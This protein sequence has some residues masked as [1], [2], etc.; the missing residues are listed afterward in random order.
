MSLSPFIQALLNLTRKR[1]VFI[2]YY[3]DGDQLYYD[4]FSRV[5]SQTYGIVRDNSVMRLILS[6]DAEY[7][8]RRIRE[9]H[10]TGSSCTI[11]LCGPGTPER[12]FVDWEIKATLDKEH[13]LIGVRLPHLPIVP[14]PPNGACYK[15]A[16]LQD[17][18]NSGYAVW[19]DWQ[20]IMKGPLS[21]KALIEDAI[22]RPKFCIDNSRSL[23]VRN[24][25]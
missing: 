9:E 11:V 24:G 10:L 23:R 4:A 8:M 15:P 2:S 17:N 13:G 16:R 20:T 7:Q 5:F 1:S 6:D 25:D 21:L 14:L 18:I 19:T 12:K 3:H 22:G